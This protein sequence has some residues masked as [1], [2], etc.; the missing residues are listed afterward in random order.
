MAFKMKSGPMARNYGY[1]FKDEGDHKHPHG[2]KVGR[3]GPGDRFREDNSSEE[4]R[5]L[6][7]SRDLDFEGQSL[8]ASTALSPKAKKELERRIA[9]GAANQEYTKSLGAPTGQEVVE[10]AKRAEDNK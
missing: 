2:K 6:N 1:P 9:L 5:V 7:D 10:S 8:D 4:M 3:G